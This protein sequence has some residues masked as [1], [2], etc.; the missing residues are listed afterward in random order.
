M[1]DFPTL[2][3]AIKGLGIAGGPVFAVLWWLERLERKECQATTKEMLTQVLNTTHQATTT[4]TTITA[5]VVELR[6]IMHNSTT[7]LS[8][9]IRSMKKSA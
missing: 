1:A 3:E 4:V 2:F 9:L 7:S 6:A 5:A 8:Q